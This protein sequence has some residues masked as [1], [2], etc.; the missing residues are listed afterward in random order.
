MDY[1]KRLE[2]L[3]LTSLQ[4][5]RERYIIINAWKIL[6]G[7]IPNDIEMKFYPN[8]RLGTKAR[9]PPLAK[10]C[11]S[12]VQTMYENSFAVKAAKLWNMLP[13]SI[14][15]IGELPAFKSALGLLLE[16]VPDNPPTAGYTA[17]CSNSLLDWNLQSGGL[18]DV[19]WP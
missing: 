18:R 13:K 9:I 11:P 17:V 15:T 10:N 8:E 2:Y 16:K 6:N 3:K 14:N 7:K 12:Y 1:W 19:R 5:R 4:R